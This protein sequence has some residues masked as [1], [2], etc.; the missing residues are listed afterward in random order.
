ML[1]DPEKIAAGLSEALCPTCGQ[2]RADAALD[3]Q[4]FSLR[5]RL[6]MAERNMSY[7]EVAGAVGSDQATIH[8][9]GKHGKP[10]R[11]ETYLAL[12]AWME[13]Q[14]APD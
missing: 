9:I 1:T 7:R 4:Q 3:W 12:S 2:F 6:T 13:N 11:A 10:I 5:L 14:N 8:R